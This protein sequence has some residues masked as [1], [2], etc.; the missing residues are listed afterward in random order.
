MVYA[1]CCVINEHAGDVPARQYRAYPK[2]SEFSA[3]AY[4]DNQLLPNSSTF[5]SATKNTQGVI[6][7]RFHSR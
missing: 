5:Y 4:C 3:L 7:G 2:Y 6:G 1:T